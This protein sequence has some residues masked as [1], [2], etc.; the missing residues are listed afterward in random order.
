MFLV[1][2]ILEFI[3]GRM[4]I[5]SITEMDS[6]CKVSLVYFELNIQYAYKTYRSI[7]SLISRIVFTF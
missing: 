1:I 3:K 2:F 4:P 6:M 5:K 7:Y